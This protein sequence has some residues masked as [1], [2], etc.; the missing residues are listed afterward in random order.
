M[1][2]RTTVKNLP[3]KRV[4]KDV[5]PQDTGIICMETIFNGKKY[6]GTSYCC[7]EDMEFFSELVGSN[8]A[9]QRA[10]INILKDEEYKAKISWHALKTAYC[11][12]YEEREYI[13]PT[14]CLAYAVCRAKEKYDIYR[15]YRKQEERVLKE[16]LEN[17]K[18]VLSSVVSYRKKMGKSG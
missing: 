15:S 8:I 10:I 7:Q 1:S 12:F 17:H 3:F 6:I 5:Y 9:V 11:N 2:L 16:Y 4:Y 18:K 14:G 13:D